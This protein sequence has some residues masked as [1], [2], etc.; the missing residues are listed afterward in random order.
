MIEEQLLGLVGS[1]GFPIGSFDTSALPDEE[2]RYP[3]AILALTSSITYHILIFV[4]LEV[5]R[6]AQRKKFPAR[7]IHARISW[8]P[9][10]VFL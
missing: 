6:F 3:H 5:R 2:A 4:L 9:E 10:I 7:T 1:V 8:G